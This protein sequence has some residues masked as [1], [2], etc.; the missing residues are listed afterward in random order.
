MHN[1][2][3]IKKLIEVDLFVATAVKQNIED[4]DDVLLAETEM[5]RI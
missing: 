3:F 1:G 5:L 4:V 2:E